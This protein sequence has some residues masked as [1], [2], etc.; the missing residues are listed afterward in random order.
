MIEVPSYRRHHVRPWRSYLRYQARWCYQ[1]L[2]RRHS[3]EPS[4]QNK[5]HHCRHHQQHRC[6]HHYHDENKHLMTG[7]EG[8]RVY[9]LRGMR[10]LLEHG[11]PLINEPLVDVNI[12]FSAGVIQ[13]HTKNV[14]HQRVHLQSNIRMKIDSLSIRLILRDGMTKRTLKI[15]CF[16]TNRPFPSC[17]EPHYESEAKRY[18]FL[19]KLVFIHMQIKLIF[20]WKAFAL[21]LAFIMRFTATRK[22]PIRIDLFAAAALSLWNKLPS[23]L[24]LKCI[25]DFSAWFV[26]AEDEYVPSIS[27]DLQY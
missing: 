10:L 6:Q 1:H 9:Y 13:V 22:W 26:N 24:L 12:F 25:S 14:P 17:C 5:R 21:S 23:K 27:F 3:D 16:G 8:G 18:V 19:S 15:Q 11:E 7:L 20:L 2:L 4:M